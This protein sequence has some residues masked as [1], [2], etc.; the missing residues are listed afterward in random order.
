MAF[1]IIR[2]PEF[3]RRVKECRENIGLSQA[4]CASDIGVSR[5]HWNN[6]EIGYCKPKGKR[7]QQIADLLECDADWLQHGEGS[8]D[9]QKMSRVLR[10][11]RIA[12]RDLDH[13]T[14]ALAKVT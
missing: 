10:M 13:I 6:W 5:Q 7:L 14:K 9:K 8:N 4:D 12:V 1:E 11:L 3:A 2:E